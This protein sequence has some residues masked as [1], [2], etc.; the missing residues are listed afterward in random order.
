[1]NFEKEEV[2][3]GKIKIRKKMKRKESGGEAC[4]AY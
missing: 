2:K 4:A 3:G 1:M